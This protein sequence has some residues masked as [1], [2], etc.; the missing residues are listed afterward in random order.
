MPPTKG[1]AEH[2]LANGVDDRL[3]AMDAMGIDMEI[4][5]I[6]PFWYGADRE[7]AGKI[8]AL[9]NDHLAKLR[10]AT[11]DRFGAFASLSMQFPTWR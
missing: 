11:P 1:V 2:F 7:V 10:A 5:S 6:N 3:R 4:L 8:V 9:Q